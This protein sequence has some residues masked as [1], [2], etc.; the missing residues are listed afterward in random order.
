M[1][2]R[3]YADGRGKRRLLEPRQTDTL[4]VSLVSRAGLER[5]DKHDQVGQV[6]NQIVV[7]KC[8]V[9][10]LQK[11]NHAPAAWAEVLCSEAGV[12]EG[13]VPVRNTS[14]RIF[15]EVAP[16]PASPRAWSSASSLIC[17]AAFSSAV[18]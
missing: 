13:R 12:F 14:R 17:R 16:I 3:E 15:L 5:D 9:R 10:N 2:G 1:R 11:M 6:G 4:E 18:R 7:E 8:L